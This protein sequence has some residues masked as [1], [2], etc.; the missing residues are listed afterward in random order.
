MFGGKRRTDP[1]TLGELVSALPKLTS[2]LQSRS[3]AAN[4]VLGHALRLLSETLWADYQAQ[5]PLRPTDVTEPEFRR[6][7]ARSRIDLVGRAIFG[8]RSRFGLDT[9]ADDPSGPANIPMAASPD[10]DGEIIVSRE[11]FLDRWKLEPGDNKPIR[12]LAG[13]CEPKRLA[14]ASAAAADAV[15]HM[16]SSH[17]NFLEVTRRLS[18]TLR[19]QSMASRPVRFAPLLL[20]GPPGIG[21]TRYL[22]RLAQ[23][24]TRE[25]DQFQSLILPMA[26]HSDTLSLSGNSRGWGN[27]TPGR[28]VRFMSATRYANPIMILDEID[29]VGGTNDTRVADILLNLLEREQSRAFQDM[30]LEIPV[31]L[32]RVSFVATANDLDRIPGPLRDRFLKIEVAPPGREDLPVVARE[33]W[34]ELLAEEGLLGLAPDEPPSAILALGSPREMQTIG[35]GLLYQLVAER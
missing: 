2:L 3:E 12:H 34:H 4:N 8:R 29:K 17:P 33:V 20:H 27:A 24:I 9:F 21:K 13:L 35:R 15:E 5:L 16:G 1:G 14:M 11:G 6:A 30:Y 7:Y 26:G 18:I 32:S 31:D 22:H 25:N 23:A 28:L 10:E 19:A